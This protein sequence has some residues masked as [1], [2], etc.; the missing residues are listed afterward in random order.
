M[1]DIRYIT[2]HN[3]AD[4]RRAFTGAAKPAPAFGHGREGIAYPARTGGTRV[5]VTALRLARAAGY[6][7]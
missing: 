2:Q 5:G 1:I 6:G 4:V 3:G 7:V